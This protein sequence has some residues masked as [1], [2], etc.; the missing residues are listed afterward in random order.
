MSINQWIGVEETSPNG[1]VIAIN[2]Q[3]CFHA[4]DIL[5]MFSFNRANFAFDVILMLGCILVFYLIGF[6]G[7]LIRVKIS[8]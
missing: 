3:E 6:V 8:R 2:D 1:C 7:L 4:D 5:E